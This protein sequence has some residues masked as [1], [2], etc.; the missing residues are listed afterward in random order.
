MSQ[1][2][3]DTNQTS[4]CVEVPTEGGTL[5]IQAGTFVDNSSGGLDA[6]SLRVVAPLVP[7]D[8]FTIANYGTVS[9]NGWFQNQTAINLDAP[10]IGT[11]EIDN[12]GTIM[13]AA[14]GV[15]DVNGPLSLVVQNSNLIESYGNDAIVTNAAATISNTGTI[16]SSFGAGVYVLGAGEST[17]INDG[18]ISAASS[19][20]VLI[21]GGATVANSGSITSGSSYG[22][23][24]EGTSTL[25]DAGLIAG[26]SGIAVKF[27]GS[28]TD[29]LILD[30]SA[31]FAG[32]VA[33]STAVGATNTME[34][35]PVAAQVE[36]AAFANFSQVTVDFG[37]T[38]TVGND[39][40]GGAS[41]INDGT[42][43]VANGVTQVLGNLSSDVG[44]QGTI[45]IGAGAVLA[46][47][48]QV[49]SQVIAFTGANGALEVSSA[50]ALTLAGLAP[51]DLVDL[52]NVPS[53]GPGPV[54][55]AL[56]D[57]GSEIVVTSGQHSADLFLT[58]PLAA[59]ERVVTAPD[60]GGGTDISVAAFDPASVSLAA[61][62]VVEA[63]TTSNLGLTLQDAL[64]AA[65]D[66]T[67][68]VT[69]S[70]LSGQF[71][72][73]STHASGSGSAGLTI[74]GTL[75]QV[76]AALAELQDVAPSSAGSDT[77][78]VAM[79]DD[80][81][82]SVGTTQ[83]VTAYA[84][85]TVPGAPEVATVA[86]SAV[87]V[88]GLQ[89]TDAYVAAEGGNVTVTLSTAAGTL[90]LAQPA[91]STATGAGIG[92][93]V[94]TGSLA[95]VNA[96]LARL[97]ITGSVLPHADPLQITVQDAQGADFVTTAPVNSAPDRLFWTN[98]LT[99]SFESPGAWTLPVPQPGIHFAPDSNTLAE[100]I[101]DGPS[102]IAVGGNGI[103]GEM[104]V[105]HSAVTLAGE[106]TLDGDLPTALQVWDG[107]LN[108]ASGAQVAL[109]GT[110]N[111]QIG[112]G[113]HATT[114]VTAGTLTAAT[115]DVVPDARVEIAAGGTL[116]VAGGIVN[117]G[118][119]ALDPGTTQHLVSVTS[120][121]PGGTV[122]IGSGAT[123]TVDQGIGPREVVRFDGG[124]GALVLNG[125]QAQ[126][127]E[128][129][130]LPFGTRID[131]AGLNA[132]GNVTYSVSPDGT[133]VVV[134]DGTHA[135]MITLDTPIAAGDRLMT[136]ADGHG[137]VN[138]TAAA[139]APPSLTVAPTAT[140][141][142]GVA[143]ALAVGV[144][145]PLETVS[146]GQLTLTVAAQ[147]GDL[148][149]VAA[150][151][152]GSGTG[153]LTFTGTLAQI[154]AALGGLQYHA[155]GSQ[156]ADVI[157]T[158]LHDDAGA[159]TSAVENVTAYA[160]PETV[161][162]ASALAITGVY[163]PVAGVQVSDA[164][165]AAEGGIITV[166]LTA[167]TGT[168]LL[169]SPAH[170]TATGSTGIQ[171]QGVLTLTG[172]L[173]AVNADLANLLYA[174]PAAGNATLSVQVQDS[175]GGST[176]TQAALITDNN[177][178]SWTAPVNG[179]FGTPAGWSV[180]DGP[181]P[182]AP[183]SLTLV[184]FQTGNSAAYT[185]SGN[186]SAA[187]MVIQADTV[188]MTGDVSVG[189]SLGTSV[190]VETG[191]L[192]VGAGGSLNAAGT[193]VVGT[194][195]SPAQLVVQ[196]LLA[197]HDIDVAHGATLEVAQQATGSAQLALT[198]GGIVNDGTIWV[199]DHTTLTLGAVVNEG[200]A[201]TIDL[202]NDSN[203]RL[204]Q[205]LGQQTA[206]FTTS[207]GTLA[208]NGFAGGAI[209]NMPVGATVD[210]LDMNGASGRVTGTLLHNGTTI[211]VSD[212]THT[213]DLTLEAPAPLGTRVVTASDAT[214]GIAVT[215]S[216]FSPAALTG[217][218][219]QTMEAGRALALG[220]GVADPYEAMFGGTL[221]LQVTAAHG[222]L[223]D[224]AAHVSGS[225]T[226]M[227][228]ITGTFAQV[229]TALGQLSFAAAA[230]Q[231]GDTISAT[232]QDAAGGTATYTQSVTALGGPQATVP[233]GSAIGVA[234][235]AVPVA[236]LQV[237][238][239]YV[240]NQGG[241]VSVMLTVGSGTLLL[242]QPAASVATGSTALAPTGTLTLSGSLS[243]VNTDLAH[244]TFTGGASV[245]ASVAM[246]VQDSAGGS[247]QATL[248]VQVVPGALSWA[249]ARSAAFGTGSSWSVA[250]APGATVA[251]NPLLAVTF[252]TGSATPYTVSGNGV[253]AAMVVAG[254]TLTT[255][256]SLGINGVTPGALL[257][258]AGS[259]TVADAST[260][261]VAGTARI[262]GGPAA[263]TT[264]VQG[265]LN[266]AGLT[267]AAGGTLGV[268]VGA[269]L[270]G[271]ISLGGGTFQALADGDDAQ[272][273]GPVSLTGPVAANNAAVSHIQAT[274]AALDIGGGLA[275]AGE[276][277]VTGDV[278]V[279]GSGS[280]TGEVM[281]QGGT[282]CLT[283]AAAI[284]TAAIATASGTT[285]EVDL[286]PAGNAVTSAGADR[287]VLGG[288]TDQISVSGAAT[289]VGGAGSATVHATGASVSVIGGSGSIVLT[290]SAD[291]V[292]SDTA[293]GTVIDE[294]TGHVTF[295]GGGTG[296]ATV[297]AAS[298]GTITTGTGQTALT[299][300]NQ[301]AVVTSRGS[302]TIH[303]GSGAATVFGAGATT[304]VIGGSGGL[305]FA[306]G[307]GQ[308]S[309]TG[310]TASAT[311]FGGA[312]GG[313]LQGGGA[314]GNIL[315]ASGGNTTL[316]GAGSG[317][318]MFAVGGATTMVGGQG[319]G[320]LMV[321]G[322][323][324]TSMQAFGGATEFAG[325]GG[326][327]EVAGSGPATLVGGSQ[328]L[329]VMRGGTANTVFVGG[330]GS[331]SAVGGSGNDTFVLGSGHAAVSEGDGADTV[332]FGGGSATVQA[333]T[334]HD[335][336]DV[337]H[338]VAGGSGVVSGFNTAT[339]SL[340]LFGYALNSANLHA[341]G[342]TAVLSLADGTRIELTGVTNAGAVHLVFG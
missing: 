87:P 103:A 142:I 279:G 77:I 166:A 278:S 322:A 231:A 254:D 317:N 26:G 235:A 118:T 318:Q 171:P 329:T 130:G 141:E 119:L 146:G 203:V 113:A 225:G 197:A 189:D 7:V 263:A 152:S 334:G 129:A 280:A 303:G 40:F 217:P 139:Y 160:G 313:T 324:Q 293:G 196:G 23:L 240:L 181:S 282:L 109:T 296:A 62:A 195:A 310:G 84:G 187:A 283:S 215:L 253:A 199:G 169:S 214:G 72:D 220:L 174:G 6:S 147:H 281:L 260:I 332:L 112:D 209:A 264:L 106:I 25:V 175:H 32:R 107:S 2:I 164:Y 89:V 158:S 15:M 224:A 133:Q 49:S 233:F 311:L 242:S 321:G 85:P 288:G 239:P 68:T 234:G 154:Q 105:A 319:G 206:A 314:G 249:T 78:T 325:T 193:L 79:T 101:A 182:A 331:V 302:D 338:G 237:F 131:L 50:P 291:A 236:G 180:Q 22:V 92:S 52:A 229:Q 31:V 80:A 102:A 110:S 157:T 42:L 65:T 245:S 315:V 232:L 261:D 295:V 186:G 179:A 238:D 67:I 9:A 122:E 207:M 88:V 267:V 170:S 132:S 223:T 323:G 227:I 213:V 216:P 70:A 66:G 340:N 41:V 178:L 111:A 300:G 4:G 20:G 286:G 271:Q 336:F 269:S 47:T 257:V 255:V 140:V 297:T 137:G 258:G 14:Q 272:A 312:G 326:G 81:G 335:S 250:G 241:T 27:E 191:S 39:D 11:L 287:I 37:A 330:A 262:G 145:D 243:A 265:T 35:A 162:P 173:A 135:D 150:I 176:S 270:L 256:G 91:Q 226:G 95:A 230:G 172:S 114:L 156:T 97:L 121:G 98:G 123:L 294:G 149:D 165:V 192:T 55:Y 33:G 185:V 308:A 307:T 221:A 198:G 184:S 126:A 208:L 316:V 290:G 28:G 69:V 125:A 64:E 248:P 244:L 117:D 163:V 58:T 284:G 10:G 115:L 155:A 190:I 144:A 108:I 327:T 333:G 328:G 46:L 228:S 99:G 17:L 210:L 309:V 60:G 19:F 320:D 159:A 71:T 292:I 44:H 298:G 76:D 143:A 183:D 134:A 128:L 43:I 38:W 148:T 63:G 305:L 251:P 337:V 8:S 167:S 289:V 201:G 13:G 124:T 247:A 57:A 93:L 29:R 21:A 266:T 61:S 304:Q 73:A 136:S 268:D 24:L 56:A 1:D 277:I 12:S 299:L 259:L 51:G 252:A 82:A 127:V 138:L 341:E 274:S 275:G 153:T 74:T 96:D 205:G 59:H 16:R 34:L 100:F 104:V 200:S 211:E 5:D 342:G 218:A 54:T 120:G 161:V 202:G 83:T 285:N 222:T 48:G 219:A 75:S 204:T 36:N 90:S 194:G 276:V 168:L 116:V 212:G 177:Q 45:D 301:A 188:T 151:A 53:G 306:G 18:T 3:I 339:D 94:L 30:G 86:G 273:R 246:R